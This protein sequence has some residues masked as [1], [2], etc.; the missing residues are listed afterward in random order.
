MVSPGAGTDGPL[1]GLVTTDPEYLYGG[2]P[3]LVPITDALARRA[4]AAATPRWRDGS[5]DWSAF[6]LLV[7]RSPWD[8]SVHV[9]EFRRWLDRVEQV[10]V[11]CNCPDLV[12]WNMD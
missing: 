3:D 12:R 11:L 9:E 5:V 8:Y 6:D 4:V 1:V 2:D 7:L 10:T